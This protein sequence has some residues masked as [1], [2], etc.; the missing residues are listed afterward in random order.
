VTRKPGSREKIAGITKSVI[1]VNCGMR[2]T[3]N[4]V[5]SIYKKEASPRSIL[6]E[7]VAREPGYLFITGQNRVRQSCGDAVRPDVPHGDFPL[8]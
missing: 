2:S 4:A 8:P 7:A 6:A 3:A 1:R 5:L